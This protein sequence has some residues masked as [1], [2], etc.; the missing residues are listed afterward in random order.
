MGNYPYH[1]STPFLSLQMY[2]PPFVLDLRTRGLYTLPVFC[3]ALM[4]RDQRSFDVQ[5][6]ICIP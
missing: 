1:G 6:F 5:I 4:V 2:E 3:D